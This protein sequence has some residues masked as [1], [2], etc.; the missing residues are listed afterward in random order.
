MA[1]EYYNW[2]SGTLKQSHNH[3]A[4]MFSTRSSTPN[5]GQKAKL[6]Q[7]SGTA[8]TAWW[9]APFSSLN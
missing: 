5:Y 9:Q 4:G 3:T 2:K 8:S 7:D 1:I 6:Y